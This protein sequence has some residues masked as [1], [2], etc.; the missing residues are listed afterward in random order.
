MSAD[1]R[2][3]SF[4]ESL[5]ESI[6]RNGREL[7]ARWLAELMTILPVEAQ[8]IFPTD[9]LLDHVPD[10]LDQIGQYVATPANAEIHANTMV[11]AKARE[12]G[13]LRHQQQASVHQLLRE[14]EIL[15]RVLEDFVAD[16]IERLGLTPSPRTCL[17]VV[18]RINR[19]LYALMQTTV[20]T[21]VSEYTA[22]V[23]AHTAK[24][25]SFN[26][27]LSHELRNPL[28]TLQFA[29]E[30]LA[31][32]TAG[33]E[34]HQHV[35]D[36]I[37]RNV[38][39]ASAVTR[40]LARLAQ[41]ESLLD[42]PGEQRIELDSIAQEVTRQLAEMAESR[43][44]TLRVADGL[45]VMT[46]D[47]GKLELVLIN[48][49]SNAIKYSDPHKTERFVEIDAET[50]PERVLLIVRDNGLGIPLEHRQAIFQRSFRAHAELDGEL[51]NDGFGMGLT[52]VQE[53][54]RELNGSIDV[55]STP[56]QGSC[57]TIGL[58]HRNS[59]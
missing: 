49:V 18:Q 29:A 57:F 42:S 4:G 21:F 38:K 14:Y 31:R 55:E 50:G 23:E 32:R 39:H 37:A 54:L 56:G 48:L 9:A 41:A 27:M 59:E 15:G 12:F 33:D 20:D 40:G 45:P 43:G 25:R 26:Q 24:L 10:L 51:G 19:A 28:N 46:V 8:A 58:P 5:G 3:P 16:E 6:R 22:T 53:C 13:Q 44:V 35:A 1:V 17:E 2:T 7:S 47:A 30:L 11:L 36:L 52:I 34:S